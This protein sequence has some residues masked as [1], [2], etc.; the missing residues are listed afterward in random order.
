MIEMVM[1]EERRT[2]AQHAAWEHGAGAMVHVLAMVPQPQ[3]HPCPYT[4]SPAPW[5]VTIAQH[6]AWEQG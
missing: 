2:I 6:K 5:W 4:P 3:L 1:A